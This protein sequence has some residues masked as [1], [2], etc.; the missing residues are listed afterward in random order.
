MSAVKYEEYLRSEAWAEQRRSALFFARNRCQLC[1]SQDRL[2]VHHRTYERLG[3]ESP[4]DLTVLCWSCHKKFHDRLPKPPQ[5]R[6]VVGGSHEPRLLRIMLLGV[7]WVER[8]SEVVAVED[9]DDPYHRAIYAALVDDPAL[10]DAPAS[11]DPVAARRLEELLS[12]PDDTDRPIEAFTDV[13]RRFRIAAL[14]R[15]IERLGRAALAASGE[16]RRRLEEERKTLI[17]ERREIDPPL[18]RQ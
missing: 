2:E 1:N 14:N 5:P 3:N 15:Q 18:G 4:E 17:Q 11:M 10:R 8:A 16:E 12:D 9:F 13:V 6:A 7:E